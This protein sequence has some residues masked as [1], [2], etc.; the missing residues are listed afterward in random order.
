MTEQKKS[1]VYSWESRDKDLRR[2]NQLYAAKSN[3]W[4][5]QKKRADELKKQLDKKQKKIKE[6]S[7]LLNK[8]EQ[9]R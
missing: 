6:L 7:K 9:G 3:A 8:M 1:P 2:L 5:A 4:V